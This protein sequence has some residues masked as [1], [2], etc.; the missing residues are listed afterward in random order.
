MPKL[1]TR[2]DELRDRALEP[3]LPTRLDDLRDRA[4]VPK[5][6]TRLDDLRDFDLRLLE[7]LDDL[8]LDRLFLAL[9]T[10]I[11]ETRILREDF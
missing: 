4:F 10:L 9:G 7:R 11:T 8:L 5:L 2:L 1:P 3:K 6:R